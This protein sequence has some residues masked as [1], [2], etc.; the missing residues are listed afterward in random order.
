MLLNT[1]PFFFQRTLGHLIRDILESSP[2]FL[3]LFCFVVGW[4]SVH[5]MVKKEGKH[6]FYGL[7]HQPIKFHSSREPKPSQLTRRN[8]SPFFPSI[9]VGFFKITFDRGNRSPQ[10][11]LRCI[12]HSFTDRLVKKYMLES[13][14][15]VTT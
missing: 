1:I 12:L 6:N 10:F 3:H 11:F 2:L 14:R 5:L 13:C 8:L 4:M 9:R 15:F 7:S